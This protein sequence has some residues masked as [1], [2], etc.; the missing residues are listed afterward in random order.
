[1]MNCRRIAAQKASS[2]LSRSEWSGRGGVFSSWAS[3]L[4]RKASEAATPVAAVE[5]KRRRSS[6]KPP[7]SRD[8]RKALW[9]D[10]GGPGKKRKGG[11]R[12]KNMSCAG[13]RAG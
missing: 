6:M 13:G 4:P 1:M 2:F 8:E 9:Y 3:R 5:R 10:C 7:A 12:E 11:G